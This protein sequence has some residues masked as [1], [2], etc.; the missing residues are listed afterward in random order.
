MYNRVAPA[1]NLPKRNPQT[2]AELQPQL[3]SERS[4]LVLSKIKTYIFLL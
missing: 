1:E 2:P 4:K 3:V